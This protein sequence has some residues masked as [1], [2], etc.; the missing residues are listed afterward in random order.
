MFIYYLLFYLIQSLNSQICSIDNPTHIDNCTIAINTSNYCCYSNLHY[1]NDTNSL[2]VLIPKNI[3]FIS[4]YIKVM[5]LPGSDPI[6]VDIDCGMKEIKN[7]TCGNPNPNDIDDCKKFSTSNRSCCLFKS[8]KS[9][10]C[11]YND[12]NLYYNQEIF[13]YNLICNGSYLKLGFFIIIIF[14]L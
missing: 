8:D 7:Y 5:K 4:S 10:M 13:G 2:C 1:K 3:G 9:S 11:F 14:F 6:N 12:N